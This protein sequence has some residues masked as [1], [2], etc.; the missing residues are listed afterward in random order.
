MSLTPREPDV[1]AEP[2]PHR[3]SPPPPPPA[4]LAVWIALGFGS[5]LL[6]PGPG[7]WGSL[8]ALGLGAGLWALAGPIALFAAAIAAC[9]VGVWAAGRYQHLTGRHDAP[10][11]VVDEFAGQWIALAALPLAGSALTLQGAAAAFVLFRLFDIWKPGPIGW[12]DARLAGGVGVMA[13]DILA[14]LLTGGILWALVV[15]G[16][17]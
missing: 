15:Y 9:G 7:T 8:A 1:E 16:G 11:V 10:E 13:D 17:L 12:A 6:R 2:P 4:S 3:K 14:G 5:G